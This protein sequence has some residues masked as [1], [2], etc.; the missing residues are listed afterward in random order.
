MNTPT[1]SM[2]PGSDDE[3]DL[4]ALLRSAGPRD[5]ASAELRAQV[6]AAV[7][8]EWRATVEARQRHRRF[9]PLLAV[10]SVATIAVATW[11]AQPL[12]RQEV[13]PVATVALMTGAVQV[14]H[15]AGGRWVPL[16]ATGTV[17]TGDDIQTAGDGRVAL[18]LDDGIEVRL[19]IQS[20]L[21]LGDAG[22]ARL[23]HGAVYVD[24]GA[25]AHNEGVTFVLGT[26]AGDVR[27]LGTQYA[28]RTL[29]GTVL[30]NV[31][32]GSVA[33]ERGRDRIVGNAG[34]QLSVTS[35]GAVVRT[36]ISPRDTQWAWVESIAPPFAIEGRPLDDF[37]A[38]AAR[39]TGRQLVY[40]SPA[41]AADAASI[42]LKG[43]VAG[44][45]PDA[46]LAAV[47]TTTPSL[48][49]AV[50]DTHIRVEHVAEG[51]LRTE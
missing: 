17:N 3:R 37:V 43:S 24:A 15:A 32:E 35:G 23:E 51:G 48:R 14:R 31:R 2:P 22:S 12:L 33:I 25:T 49:A 38:W 28:V 44:L 29:D 26:P 9:V 21:T 41:A 39:E 1:S 47:F 46:A 40:A 34:E 16:A 18:R 42:K 7:A 20:Q 6:Q 19:D 13:D 30:V 4:A 45:G 10:A 5:Q 27:H 50:G 36:T 11:L 8:A